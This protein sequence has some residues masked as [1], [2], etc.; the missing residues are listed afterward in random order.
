VDLTQEEIDRIVALTPG[1]AE[2][3]QDIYPLAPLQEGILFHHQV[4]TQGDPYLQANLLSLDNRQRLDAYVRSLQAVVDR[5][6]ILRTAVVWEGLR[7]PVQVVHRK[8]VLQVEEMQVD[9]RAGDVAQQLYERLSP[10]HFRIDVRQAPLLRCYITQDDVDP[11]RWF[12]VTLLHHL[13]GDH[14]TV[15]LMQEEI[16]AS[17]LGGLDQLPAPQPFRNLVAHARLEASQKEHEQFF[18]RMLADVDEP[19]APFG[20]L[21][22]QGDGS[23]VVDAKSYLDNELT[24]RLRQCAR[25]VGVT[26]AS[27]FHVAWA[28]VVAK[29]SGRHDVVFG[30]VLLGRMQGGAGADRA[31]GLL[32]N[33]LPIRIKVGN[34][35][36]EAITRRTQHLLA[37]LLEHEHV[38]LAL[39]QRWSR[40]PNGTPLFTSLLNYRHTPSRMR[41]PGAR[42]ARQGIHWLRGAARTNYPLTFSIDDTDEG[43]SFVAEVLKPIDPK[44]VCAFMSTAIA[45]LVDAL[46][47]TPTKAICRLDVLPEIELYRVLCGGRE[48]AF[49]SRAGKCVH[50]LFEE[51]A[52]ENPSA[53]A[54]VFDGVR[55][56]YRELNRRANQV[57]HSLR[58]L[59]VGPEIRVGICAERTLEMSVGLLAVLKAGGV[60]VPLNPTHSTERLLS[61]LEDTQPLCILATRTATLPVFE[62]RLVLPILGEGDPVLPFVQNATYHETNLTHRIDPQ[63]AACVLYSTERS[64]GV[65]VTHEQFASCVALKINPQLEERRVF[66]SA[67]W[68]IDQAILPLCMSLLSGGTLIGASD[69]THRSTLAE[70]LRKQRITHAFLSPIEASSLLKAEDLDSI[71]IWHR[72]SWSA[73]LR[74]RQ[75]TDSGFTQ[76]ATLNEAAW[77]ALSEP[78]TSECLFGIGARPGS[79]AFILDGQLQLAPVGVTGELYLG[80]IALARCYLNRSVLTAERFVAN[81]YGQPGS[82]LYRTGQLARWHIEGMLELVQLRGHEVKIRGFRINPLELEHLLLKQEGVAQAAIAVQSDSNGTKVLIAY[83]ASSL[84]S[85]PDLDCLEQLLRGVLPVPSLLGAVV[86]LP[87]LPVNT[88]GLPER[89]LLPPQHI[90]RTPGQVRVRKLTAR[91]RSKG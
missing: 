37:D 35:T 82:R 53:I 62:G 69:I 23:N 34:E 8:A 58:E 18:R 32:M 4:S 80:N 71:K 90:A 88:L 57:A 79:E 68:N 21:D 29:L 5:H 11:G 64:T 66:Q 48:T 72:G 12:M 45:S 26:A 41:P 84:G 38:P 42:E 36:V 1:G 52:N 17:L 3:I 19:T 9:P 47:H 30:T 55:L 6:D 54:I 76:L 10:R 56:S 24:R 46:E 74:I 15:E 7:E 39:A 28:R 13:V 33:T 60:Y 83:V 91:G 70:Y 16:Q 22:I 44:R 65:V 27:L 20:L 61:V 75:W 2:N 25:R 78:R 51:Q 73:D 67:L 49:E 59:G 50:E 63:N 85:V 86:A 40:V 87:E 43:F 14:T 89:A 77:A 81:P 31:M